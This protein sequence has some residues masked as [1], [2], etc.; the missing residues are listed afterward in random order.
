MR[1]DTRRAVSRLK[2]TIAVISSSSLQVWIREFDLQLYLRLKEDLWSVDPKREGWYF[3]HW[4][5]KLLNRLTPEQLHYRVYLRG[6]SQ[7]LCT[8]ERRG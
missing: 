3:A 8:F 5:N 2:Y 4:G 1:L 6:N 7:F